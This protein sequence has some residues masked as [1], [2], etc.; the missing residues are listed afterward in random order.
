MTIGGGGDVSAAYVCVRA[1]S[2]SARP[3]PL[4]QAAGE[5]ALMQVGRVC[6][7]CCRSLHCDESSSSS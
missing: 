2:S 4:Q 5:L 3:L 1:C 7:T 6:G